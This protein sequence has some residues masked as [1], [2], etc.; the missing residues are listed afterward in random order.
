[1]SNGCPDFI[2]LTERERLPR[3]LLVMNRPWLR[4][5][6]VI[7][8]LLLQSTA[9][10]R[11]LS[12]TSGDMAA[13]ADDSHT[14]CHSMLVDQPAQPLSFDSPDCCQADTQ[15]QEICAAM[16]AVTCTDLTM[17]RVAPLSA[18]FEFVSAALNG[19]YLP[20]I[21]KPPIHL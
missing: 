17:R 1:M 20:D 6:C 2:S 3:L 21:L 16:A 5:V 13:E 7:C 19:P 11:G 12:M 4:T 9:G 10:A 15:C 8:V 14:A 18:H